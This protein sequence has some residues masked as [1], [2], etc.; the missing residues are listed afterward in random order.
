MLRFFRSVWRYLGELGDWLGDRGPKP[1]W[2]R[3]RPK[4]FNTLD[5][6]LQDYLASLPDDAA[7]RKFLAEAAA[8]REAEAKRS[9]T[10]K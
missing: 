6:I 3:F 2:P 8:E 10:Q 4:Q 7:R 9:A 1:R 5:E